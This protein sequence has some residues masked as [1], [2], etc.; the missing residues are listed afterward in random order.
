MLLTRR[1]AIYFYPA[2]NGDA[3]A[4][5]ATLRL[6]LFSESSLQ[7]DAI[8]AKEFI[9]TLVSI[10]PLPGLHLTTTREQHWPDKTGWTQLIELATKT[11]A[12]GELDKVVLARATDLHFASPVNA[13]AMMAASRRLNLNCYHFYMAFDGENAF[14]GSSPERLWRR[15]DKALRT[16][17]LAGTVANNPDDKQAQQLGEWLMADDKKP[18]R[19]HA[20]GG[21]YLPTITGRYPDAG[22]FTAAGT[23][24]A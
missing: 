1:R 4:V 6:T 16:E 18:A 24:S 20:G 22:C 14:L 8:Q 9:A 21:R 3:V 10:K 2:W 13:A 12:E 17:A 19:E 7:H 23:A 15:R 11:I 5:K